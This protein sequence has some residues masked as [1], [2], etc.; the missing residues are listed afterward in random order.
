MLDVICTHCGK[1]LKIPERYMGQK[2]KCNHCQGEITVKAASNEI[3]DTTTFLQDLL[4]A[5]APEFPADLFGTEGNRDIPEPPP[6][7]QQAPPE[8]PADLFGAE[9]V[10]RGE[11]GKRETSTLLQA[12]LVENKL[13]AFFCRRRILWVGF[14]LATLLSSA[15]L[16]GWLARATGGGDQ[17]SGSTDL[18]KAVANQIDTRKTIAKK[19]KVSHGAPVPFDYRTISKKQK[20]TW[21]HLVTLELETT[22]E[23]AKK[24]TED[25][26][27]RLWQH[28][29][30]SLGDRC[31]VNVS[32]RTPV[33]EASPWALINRLN[34]KM[35]HSGEWKVSIEIY[36]NC[37][38][39][40]AVPFCFFNQI[41]RSV[42]G[43][44]MMIVTLPVVNRVNEQL[45]RRGWQVEDRSERRFCARSNGVGHQSV[46]VTL[47]P[48][49]VS[50]NV[51][52]FS[53]A[54]GNT[55]M[56]TVD[57]V[58]G[59]LGIADE[60]KDRL[61]SVI[62]SPEYLRAASGEHAS[63]TFRIGEIRVMYIRLNGI[64]DLSADHI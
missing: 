51:T 2:G 33:P 49:S 6:V 44:K 47:T 26:L 53:L 21:G 40:D 28:I 62:G 39:I 7:P 37:W 4:R 38:T 61:Y 64:D 24:A 52:T 17:K 8:F 54:E 19:A 59:E 42:Q 13:R 60:L 50:I 12:P 23:V 36:K 63:W 58:F 3:P 27:R 57:I 46:S 16:I 1:I 14:L 29:E 22:N 32:L 31:A 55:F 48:E 41:D 20:D 10:E 9:V 5:P 11:D 45:I 30:P 25:D 56:D 43:Q 18:S 34:T 35:D 15:V